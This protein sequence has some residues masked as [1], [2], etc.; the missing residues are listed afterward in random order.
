MDLQL[1]DR[2]VMVTGSGGGMGQQ[3][4][5]DF[6]AEGATVIVNDINEQG[7]AQTVAQIGDAGGRAVSAPCDITALAAVTALVQRI[8]AQH[9]R[10]DILVNNAAVLV[11][12]ALF[13]D[14]RPEDCA[15]EMAVI[16]HGTMNCARAALPGMVARRYGKIV[17]IVTDAARVGQE[18]EVNYSA[19]KGGVVSF[20]KSIA[21]E[22]GPHNINV[23]AVSPAATN[24]PMR[25]HALQ[26]MAEKIGTDKLQ[27]REARVRRAYPLRRIG[28]PEDVSHTVLF[29]ASDVSRHITGQIVSVNGG[30]AMPG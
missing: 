14:T 5:R 15:R 18:R 13:L 12:H 24:S 7:I 3:F 2:I 28:E 22:M 6:A 9:G 21:R 29:L 26:Q 30:Y 4:A 16:L 25:Q 20:T 10:L 1:K 17:N 11:Q 19:A 23:N 8:E 27:E